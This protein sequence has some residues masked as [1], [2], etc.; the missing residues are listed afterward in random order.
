MTLVAGGGTLD[1]GTGNLTVSGAVG[2]AVPLTK[3]S[4]GALVLTG[5]NTYTGA[6]NVNQ[7][8]LALGPGGSLANTALTVGNAGRR[9]P[10]CRSTAITASA[11]AAERA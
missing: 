4:A 8:V 11:R 5:A 3:L 7:G 2:G 6:T 1:T 10:P 9:A